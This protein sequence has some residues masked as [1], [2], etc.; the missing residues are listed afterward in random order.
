MTF[1][2][3]KYHAVDFQDGL[4]DFIAQINHPHA[5]VMALQAL[6]EDTLLSFCTV[7]VGNADISSLE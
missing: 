1:L 5:S 7:H 6:A 4:M 2:T 3:N